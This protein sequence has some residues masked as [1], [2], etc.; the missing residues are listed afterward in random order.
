MLG[1]VAKTVTAPDGR[2][3]TIRIRWL[4]WRARTRPRWL[5][6]RRRS[7]GDGKELRGGGWFDG[8][9]DFPIDF[10]GWWIL[11]AIIALA[12]LIFLV[13]PIVIFLVEL[14]VF[15][16]AVGVVVV[17]RVLMRSPWTVEAVSDGD[18]GR[19]MEWRSADL[20]TTRRA[21][22][23][24]AKAIK[25]GQRFIQPEGTHYLGERPSPV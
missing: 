2:T 1:D 25:Y 3:W 23:T 19:T 15:L 14:L 13:L 5:F 24:I 10:E 4:P 9:V 7:K 20:R 22:D 18:A 11:V 12:V 6:R 17:V 8:L 21:V 16:I